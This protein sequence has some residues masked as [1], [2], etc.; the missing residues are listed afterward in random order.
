MITTIQETARIVAPNGQKRIGAATSGD[1]GKTTTAIFCMDAYNTTGHFKNHKT[2]KILVP[3][4]VYGCCKPPEEDNIFIRQVY[5]V[6]LFITNKLIFRINHSLIKAR[7]NMQ[8]TVNVHYFNLSTKGTLNQSTSSQG[9]KR[10]R[11]LYN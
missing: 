4:S 10:A 8:Q 6:S 2:T 5:V 9:Q 11:T 3:L 1:R 7:T